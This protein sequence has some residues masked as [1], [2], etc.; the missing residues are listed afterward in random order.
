[1][2][3]KKTITLKT[4]AKELGV[5]VSTVSKALKNASD[6]STETKK[7]IRAFAKYYN[8]QP[9]VLAL[10]LRNGN[11]M[12]IGVIIPNTKNT[13]F[14]EVLYG[15]EKYVASKNYNLT[16][17]VSNESLDQEIQI[18]RKLANEK[19]DGI[20]ISLSVETQARHYYEHLLEIEKLGIPFVLF[21]S[22]SSKINC[23]KVVI[24][25]WESSYLAVQKLKNEGRKKIALIGTSCAIDTTKERIKGY[26]DGVKDYH[27]GN[28]LILQIHNL[29]FESCKDNIREFITTN[30]LD[31]IL[32]LNGDIANYCMKLIYE[33]RLRIP[34]DISFMVYSDAESTKYVNHLIHTI[35]S[36]GYRMGNLAAQLLFLKI[37]NNESNG[38]SK[39]EVVKTKI[40]ERNIFET[41]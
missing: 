17:C 31:A 7:T 23:D 18:I 27:L 4:I 39:T 11:T 9:N 25:N 22:V 32:C 6:I 40:L 21:D 15:V 33:M 1:M 10:N 28:N 26:S 13:L 38:V 16:L 36:N 29:E 24:N 3:S 35:S 2:K 37:Q 41:S 30:K 12:R 14:S 5:S 8:Y 19:I 34:E 20:I